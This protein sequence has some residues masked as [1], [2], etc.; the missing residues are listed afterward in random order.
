MVNV[1]GKA[2]LLER[3]ADPHPIGSITDE[4]LLLAAK[5]KAWVEVFEEQAAQL[6]VLI[7]EDNFGAEHLRAVVR[8]LSDAMASF[9]RLLVDMAKLNLQERR[10]H[11]NELYGRAIVTA[12][13]NT[14]SQLDLPPAT[15]EMA[16]SIIQVE[17]QAAEDDR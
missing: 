12:L 8:A 14:L 10:D 7:I 4:L 2:L 17:L 6:S 5:E 1:K 13:T 3:V 11:M 16:L 15:K 9:H